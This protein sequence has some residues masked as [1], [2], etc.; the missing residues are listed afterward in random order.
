M[1][2]LMLW[3]GC[4]IGVIAVIIA[5]GAVVGLPYPDQWQNEARV[6]VAGFG[7]WA[8]LCLTGYE[9]LTEDRVEG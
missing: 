2:L 4:S 3:A 5:A 6:M 9:L 8:G 1:R 7:M